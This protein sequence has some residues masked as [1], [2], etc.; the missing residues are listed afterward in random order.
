MFIIKNSFFILFVIIFLSCN[1]QKKVNN[2]V[3]L[4]VFFDKNNK[5]ELIFNNDSCFVLKNNLQRTYC[6]GKWEKINDENIRLSCLPP[7]NLISYTTVYKLKK[8]TVI[9]VCL[10]KEEKIIF[11]KYVLKKQR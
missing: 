8:D 9:T 3:L 11:N 7:E 6:Q 10:K 4:G 1:S 2:N 5:I